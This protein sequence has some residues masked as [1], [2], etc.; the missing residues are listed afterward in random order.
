MEGRGIFA[1]S[2][3]NEIR[4]GRITAKEA[5]EKEAHHVTKNID[6]RLYLR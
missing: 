5:A 4:M 6:F 1:Q 3:S 2:C